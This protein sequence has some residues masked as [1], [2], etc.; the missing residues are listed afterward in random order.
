[1]VRAGTARRRARWLLAPALLVAE[2]ARL[3][4]AGC[5]IDGV[6]NASKP[7]PGLAMCAPYQQSA[8]CDNGA[9]L[10]F[11]VSLYAT[12]YAAANVCMMKMLDLHCG[13]E[14]H[15]YQDAFSASVENCTATDGGPWD[16]STGV[17][18]GSAG[19]AAQCAAAASGNC[20]H[21][22]AGGTVK[23][24]GSVCT[25]LHAS[26][27]GVDNATLAD[28]ATWCESLSFP[29]AARGYNTTVVA[30]AAAAGSCYGGLALDGCDGRP[31]SGVVKDR[32]LV[33][34]GDNSTCT[35]P[36][37]ATQ[38]AIRAEL[39]S[40]LSS[41]RTSTASVLTGARFGQLGS[42]ALN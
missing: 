14:C 13:V 23:L 42:R 15:P 19:A 27:A 12:Q 40:N 31:N 22:P 32:C 21:T 3:A 18:L 38:A 36:G 35:V 6:S 39:A 16:C 29:W 20:T 37:A 7:S 2:L 1:M 41:V 24:C 30:D 5:L 25:A 11:V 33:C 34:D 8:C 17:S 9:E 26:C 10:A 28:P 4:R